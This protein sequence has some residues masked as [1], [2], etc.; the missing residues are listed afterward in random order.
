MKSFFKKYGFA[1]IFGLFS[2]MVLS[3]VITINFNNLASAINYHTDTEF[4]NATRYKSNSYMIA[5]GDK[6]ISNTPLS[7]KI[8]NGILTVEATLKNDTGKNLKIRNFA[9]MSFGGYNFAGE[10]KFDNDGT[11]N[12]GAELKVKYEV[13]ISTF[14][15]INVMPTTLNVELGATDSNNNYNE[16]DLRY[17]ISWY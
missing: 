13:N 6:N 2:L 9:I 10:V 11:L 3:I 5:S 4:D 8:E 12:N 1:L 15:N 14:K 16:Y 17:V 7:A